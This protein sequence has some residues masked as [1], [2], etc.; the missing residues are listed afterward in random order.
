VRATEGFTPTLPGLHRDLVPLYSLM[1]ATEPLPPSFWDNVGWGSHQAIDDGRHL[2]VYAQRTKDDRIAIG[3]R[4]APYHLGSAVRPAFDRRR[5]IFAALR[6]AL[7]AWF[8]ALAGVAITHEWGGPLA[9]AR[10]WQASVGY[11]RATGAAWAGGYVGDGVAASNLAGRTL[12]AL[13]TGADVAI[14]R[15]PWVG[16]QSPRW[17][18]E[19]LRWLAIN[20]S[21]RLA[22]GAD[23]AEARPARIRPW[24]L[25]KLRGR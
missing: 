21:L 16:H 14:T 1:V 9:A 18:P 2:I 4:G 5:P 7:T 8:P 22:A 19:P 25:D 13:V 6:A 17:E 20:G 24:V 3:G 10:D 12:A 15:L 23:R 11:D